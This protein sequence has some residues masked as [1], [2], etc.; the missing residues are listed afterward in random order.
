MEKQRIRAQY[1]SILYTG[2]AAILTLAF[3]RDEFFLGLVPYIVLFP[4][5]IL[6]ESINDALCKLGSYMYVF[7]EGR[8]YRWERRHQIFD[9]MMQTRHRVSRVKFLAENR[10]H[11]FMISVICSAVTTYKI[12]I[13]GMNLAQKG[14]VSVLVWVFTAVVMWM[15]AHSA[16]DFVQRREEMI[17][18]WEA[19]KARESDGEQPNK[20]QANAD[21]ST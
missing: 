10:L 2:T 5:Y 4:L 14:T 9:G 12:I 17:Q 3:T 11:Y 18:Y 6:T 7:L 15:M 1:S 19:I 13:S 16:T 21:L 20:Q 8:E